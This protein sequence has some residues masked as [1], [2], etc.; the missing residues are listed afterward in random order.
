MDTLYVCSLQLG[1]F[2]GS[3]CSCRVLFMLSDI[4]FQLLVS[5]SV[6]DRGNRSPTSKRGIYIAKYYDDEMG[7]VTAGK[8][9]EGAGRKNQNGVK[10]KEKMT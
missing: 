7:G 3:C 5:R 9:I 10:K 1:L 6:R 8:K 2:G 4:L